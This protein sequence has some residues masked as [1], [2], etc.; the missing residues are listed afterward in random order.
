MKKSIKLIL[1]PI[2]QKLSV[3]FLRKTNQLDLFTCYKLFD[4]DTDSLSIN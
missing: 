4:K 3:D 1:D 2:K